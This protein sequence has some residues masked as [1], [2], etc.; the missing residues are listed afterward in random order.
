M[1]LIEILVRKSFQNLI[2]IY[3]F[4]VNKVKNFVRDN[5]WM[6]CNFYGWQEKIHSFLSKRWWKSFRRRK[7]N[8]SLLCNVQR[9]QLNKTFPVTDDESVI[10]CSVQV[11]VCVCVLCRQRNLIA[12]L[13]DFGRFFPISAVLLFASMQTVWHL[14]IFALGRLSIFKSNDHVLRFFFHFFPLFSTYFS[15]LLQFICQS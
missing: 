3:F 7:K 4:L 5:N 15:L 9:S 10:N 12:K 1:K 14:N 13:I 8:V 11:F 2:I 6:S